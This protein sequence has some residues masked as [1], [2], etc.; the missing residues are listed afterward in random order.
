MH[1]ILNLVPVGG[2]EKAFSSL[3]LS[4]ASMSI[5]MTVVLD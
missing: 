4:F 5:A 3:A 2:P 1:F